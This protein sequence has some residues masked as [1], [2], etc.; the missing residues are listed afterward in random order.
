MLV[1]HNGD[2]V[3]VIDI[4]IVMSTQVC[5]DDVPILLGLN[6]VEFLPWWDS[7]S[8]GCLSLVLAV[9]V[10]L[11]CAS[12]CSFVSF[13]PLSSAA[14]APFLSN[15]VASLRPMISHVPSFV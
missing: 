12:H 6:C 11:L 8:F 14:P 7:H 2:I 9:V 3:I 4:V 15:V 10:R 13:E 1:C 5:D